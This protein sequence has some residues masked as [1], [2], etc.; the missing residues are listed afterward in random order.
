MAPK[1]VIFF[2]MEGSV[3]DAHHSNPEMVNMVTELA[4]TLRSRIQRHCVANTEK[5][6]QHDSSDSLKYLSLTGN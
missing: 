2:A 4:A 3:D 5:D 6:S 1:T